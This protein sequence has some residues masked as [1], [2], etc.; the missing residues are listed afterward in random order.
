M[1]EES[2]VPFAMVVQGLLGLLFA[3][4]FLEACQPASLTID[5]WLGIEKGPS[6]NN[7]WNRADL[8]GRESY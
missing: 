6:L 2:G 3:D 8:K 7:V 4:L 1:L 5:D